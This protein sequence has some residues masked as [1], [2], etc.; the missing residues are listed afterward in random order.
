MEHRGLRKEL[1]NKQNIKGEKDTVVQSGTTHTYRQRLIASINNWG[2]KSRNVF[3]DLDTK[4]SLPRIFQI[5]LET[6]AKC[7][8]RPG[9][10]NY[11]LF[12]P[13][14]FSFF[15]FPLS[16]VPPLHAQKRTANL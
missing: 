7:R 5:N 16:S 13:D 15:S 10:L 4:N 14:I 1:G 3:S 11:G 8:E 9:T 12:F 2:K 6:L